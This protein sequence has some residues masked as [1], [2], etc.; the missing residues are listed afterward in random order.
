[1]KIVSFNSATLVALFSLEAFFPTPFVGERS[2]LQLVTE[3]YKFARFPI[4]ATS[5]EEL[6]A[7]GLQFE[8]GEFA[9]REGVMT[10][11]RL[12]VH[13][14]GAVILA[15][16]SDIADAFFQDIYSWLVK[17]MAFRNVQVS[18]L[19][20]SEIVVDFDTP[21]SEAWK[22]FSAIL[23]IATRYMLEDNRPF[24]GAGPSGFSVEFRNGTV[25]LPKFVIERRTGSTM[26]QERYI[27]MAPLRTKHHVA[28]LTD[29]EKLISSSASPQPS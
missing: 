7:N 16:T 20:L 15:Q 2:A 17:D 4:A 27:C 12:S 11:Q 25:T 28:A 14:D 5:R 10:I 22:S 13:R 21:I 19:Y 18:R 6:E 29:L 26:D 9:M 8:L 23:E 1:M 24:T 3:R